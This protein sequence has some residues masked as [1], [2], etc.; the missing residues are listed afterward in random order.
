MIFNNNHGKINVKNNP[1]TNSVFESSNK[2]GHIV[3]GS[4]EFLITEGGQFIITEGG[5]RLIT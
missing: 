1:L 4:S 2:H 3:P 5:Q